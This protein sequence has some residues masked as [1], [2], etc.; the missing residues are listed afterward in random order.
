[1]RGR[2]QIPERLSSFP[3]ITNTGPVQGTGILVLIAFLLFPAVSINAQILRGRITD[4]GGA[5]MPYAS[6]YITE[7]RQGTTSNKRGLV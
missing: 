7:L 2:R 4:S 6:V 5:P 3:Y 1:M